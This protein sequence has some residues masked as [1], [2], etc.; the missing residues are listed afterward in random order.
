[1]R[2]SL[3]AAADPLLGPARPCGAP[4]PVAVACAREHQVWERRL[5][6][7]H[8]ALVAGAPMAELPA[9]GDEEEILV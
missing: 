5:G 3:L 7:A 8:L 4:K 9:A 1:L 2:G 6:D